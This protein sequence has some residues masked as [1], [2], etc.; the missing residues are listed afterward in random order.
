[1]LAGSSS[2]E[3]TPLLTVTSRPQSPSRRTS[4]DWIAAGQQ[5]V[6]KYLTFYLLGLYLLITD[7][8]DFMS[9]ASRIRMLELGLCREYYHKTDPSVIQPGGGISED[10]CKNSVIQSELAEVRGLFEPSRSSSWIHTCSSIWRPGGYGWPEADLHIGLSRNVI[11]GLLI[12]HNSA[13][14]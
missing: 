5:H 11:E 14:A 12:C 10:L 2:S 6:R 3:Q 13:A 1:M 4:E 8:P 7:T 9:E